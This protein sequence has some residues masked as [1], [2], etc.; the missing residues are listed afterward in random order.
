MVSAQKSE[1]APRASVAYHA[2]KRQRWI[3]LLFILP[4]FISMLWFDAIPFGMNLY[5]GLTDYS[6]GPIEQANWV[7]LDNF[8]RMAD[9]ELFRK[10]L[11]NTLYY[12]AFSVPLT[13]ILAFSIALL[14]NTK[15]RLLG[16]FRTVYYI[17][18][19]IP[20]VAAS[21]IFMWMFNARAGAVNQILY[22]VG[23]DPVRWLTNP[24]YVKMTLVII[25]LWGFGAQMIVFLAALQG[26]PEQ[27]YEAVAIDGGGLWARLRHIV[28]PLMTPTIFF[29]L[30]VGLIAS[31]QVF[32]TA[33]I[34]L[35]PNGGPLQSGLFYM[36]HTYN[37]AFRYFDMGYASAMSFVLFLIILFFT[38]LMVWTSNRW[39]YYGDE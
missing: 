27:L 6:V 23:I 15:V 21:V 22:A 34:M 10:G 26:I 17:P 33:Y 20:V 11:T 24:D 32:T 14:L 7:G 16:F 31:F 5:L 39:V 18:S 1:I 19:I 4:W 13:L 2:H 9:D 8:E 28:I 35:G 12:I 29:N 3:G 30:L 36:M 37:N 38:L 25:S